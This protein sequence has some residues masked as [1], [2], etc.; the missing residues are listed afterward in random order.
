MLTHLR[1]LVVGLLAA[2]LLTVAVGASSANRLSISNR[3]I[4]SVWNKLNFTDSGGEVVNVECDITIEGSLHNSTI[5]KTRG[6]LI[7][8]VTRAP[9]PQNCTGGGATIPQE[10]LPFHVR[11]DSFTGT[12]PRPSGERLQIV[13]AT[14]RMNVG[15]EC[16]YKTTAEAPAF[17]I[18]NIEANGLITGLSADVNGLIS[19]FEGSI[20]CPEAGRF[21]NTGRMTLLGTS[22]NIS[23]R[24]I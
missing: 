20:F 3:N 16:T 5:T 2:F 17:F 14:F 23:L 10:T 1:L 21:R 24:L 22:N 7:G 12:L 11:Y 15:F 19:R 18:D 4:R 6:A 13:G 8:Y 9:Q